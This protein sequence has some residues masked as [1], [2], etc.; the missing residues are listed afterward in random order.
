MGPSGPSPLSRSAV[1][2]APPMPPG[3]PSCRPPG[4]QGLDAQGSMM[5]AMTGFNALREHSRITWIE[6][7]HGWAERGLRGMQALKLPTS[8]WSA[9]RR[10][11]SGRPS[12]PPHG[13]CRVGDLGESPDVAARHRL[14]RG[15]WG[16]ARGRGGA[17][18]VAIHGLNPSLRE[19][20]GRVPISQ[21]LPA[22]T[23]R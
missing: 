3:V 13:I 19:E 6:Q 23:L 16:V 8:R 14:H 12:T 18:G 7:E 15:R 1:S 5:R 9:D 22:G 21:D 10:A 4:S 20:P 17:M 11:A 2:R